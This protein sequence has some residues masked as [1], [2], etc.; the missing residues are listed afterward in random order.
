MKLSIITI[1][2]NNRDGLRKTIESVVNQTWQEFEY[3]IIDGGSTD[4]SVEVIKEFADHID[5]WISEPDKGIYDA[6]NKGVSVAKGEYCQFLN[7]GDALSDANVVKYIVRELE[8]K[9]IYFAKTRFTDTLGVI[10]APEQITMRTLYTR[11]LPHPS[12]YIQRQLLLKFPYDE[13]LRI[14][15]DWKFWIQAIIL[16]NCTYGIID[17]IAV[18]FDTNGLSAKHKN[19]VLTER[20]VVLKQLLPHRVYI[21]YFQEINGVNYTDTNYDKLFIE[22]RK[23]NY[24]KIVYTA[25]ILLMR[26]F[27]IFKKS[28]RFIKD[29]PLRINGNTNRP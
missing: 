8:D 24:R 13:T 3:I 6:M 20:E 16:E 27:A 19:I 15:S 5:Y 14:V 21:D 22:I 2:F 26:F 9:A 25:T 28:A 18:D 12:S 7:S 23:R 10:K 17:M 11:S 1:N 29:Y 4:G